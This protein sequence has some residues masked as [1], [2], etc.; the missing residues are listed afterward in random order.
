MK[1]NRGYNISYSRVLF[2]DEEISRGGYPSAPALAKKYE[3]SESTI[4]R[5]IAYMR[6]CLNCPIEYEPSKKGYYY[7]ESVFKLPALF[8]TSDGVFSAVVALKLL[9]QYKNSPIY[10]S[11]KNIFDKFYTN[12]FGT[13]DKD[14]LWFEN[15]ILFLP[16]VST[17]NLDVGTWDILIKSMHKN[18]FIQFRYDSIYP[19]GYFPKI[20]TVAV[21]QI[22][23]KNGIWYL[24]GRSM[25]SK[26]IALYSISRLRE[27]RLLDDIYEMPDDYQYLNPESDFI[28]VYD[29]KEKITCKIKFFGKSRAYVGDRLWGEKQHIEECHDEEAIILTFD[30]GQIA[31]TLRFVMSQGKNAIV[32]EPS[33]LVQMW[34][35]EVMAMVSNITSFIDKK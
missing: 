14:K 29:Y 21:Y 10:S 5:D 34:K 11:I 28:G 3:V 17:N 33:E 1:K 7:S 8:T 15:R 26:R 4:K 25:V 31:D 13:K 32:L 16:T 19:K 6:D 22:V 30:T 27:L 35:D 12:I 2:I 18:R 24:V 20:Y 9:S 23:S